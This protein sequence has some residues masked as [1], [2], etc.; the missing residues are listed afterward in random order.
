MVSCNLIPKAIE[1]ALLI[2]I[3][4]VLRFVGIA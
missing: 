4:G 2:D 1:D 3:Y